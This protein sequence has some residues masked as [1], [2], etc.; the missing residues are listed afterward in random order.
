VAIPILKTK[1]YLPPE[2]A[3]AVA[4]PRLLARLDEGLR[5]GC[6]LV[7][8]SA[9]AG[10]GKTTLVSEW[11]ASHHRGG[12]R[13]E[14]GGAVVAPEGGMTLR[15]AQGRLPSLQVAW[16]SL[17]SG[18]NDPA[19]FLAYLAAALQSADVEVGHD[20]RA[21]LQSPQPPEAEAVLTALLNA[22]AEYPGPLA[23]VLDDYHEITAQEIHDA[24]LF[25]LDHLPPHVHLVL[26][27]RIDPPWPL[28]RL[29]ARQAMVELRVPDLRFTLDEA[30]TYVNDVM[31]L[32]LS[33]EQLAALDAR[34]EGWISGLQMAALALQAVALQASPSRD[35]S[36][37]RDVAAFVREF[38]GSHR[39]VLDYLVEEVLERQPAEV[40]TF[41]LRTSI[42]DRLTAPLCDALLER[43]DSQARLTAL[44]RANLFLVPLD[45]ERRWY[46]YHRLF[47]DLLRARL[48]RAEPDQGRALHLRA[49][50]WLEQND[51]PEAAIDHALAG[52]DLERAAELVE[53]HAEATLMRGEVATFWRWTDA[54]PAP[55]LRARPRLSLYSAMTL[56]WR[57]R[58][59]VAIE[60]LLQDVEA[61]EAG[62]KGAFAALRGLL[63]ALRGQ[64]APATEL[65]DRALEQL[66]PQE[67]FARTY[68][69]WVLS[70]LRVGRG[71]QDAMHP[72]PDGERA[73]GDVLALS[74]Q[75]GNVLLT[76][77]AECNR[78]EL[79]MRQG[80]L[81]RAAATY[82]R[83][84]DQITGDREESPPVAGQALIG[85]GEVARLRG[86]LGE[87]ARQFTEGIRL[88]EQWTQV[89]P[90]EGHMGLARV[91]WAQG[92][93]ARAWEALDV[94]RKLAVD[95]DLSELD[96]YSVAMVGAGFHVEQGEWEQVQRWAEMRGLYAY[97]DTPLHEAPGDSYDH[98][99]HKYELL[100][101]ARMLIAQGQAA[102]ARQALESLPALAERRGRPGLLIEVYA[103]QALAWQACG[104]R[105]RALDALERAL[106][107]GEPEGYLRPLLDEG[108]RMRSLIGDFRLR[109]SG[110]AGAAHLSAYV[111]RLLG[112]EEGEAASPPGAVPPAQPSALVEPLSERELEVLRLLNTPLSQPEI[113]ERL[114]VSINT[115]RTH[116][117]HVYEKL[118]VHAR[119]A[120]VERAE[121]LGLL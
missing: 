58:S 116:V 71:G 18:D 26:A 72:A 24:L 13:L 41:L 17:D 87:A 121:E 32:A 23:L 39:Y 37:A 20:V 55:L 49:S 16:L 97:L 78:A 107:L 19:R 84:L 110:R 89:G 21:A 108:E 102:E 111:E 83:A 30:T 34:T 80:H 3:R 103:L 109:I 7:L 63:A 57:G 4:R 99:M 53:R 44:E 106:V 10:F 113:A 96:D 115:V 5:P 2:R 101:L 11:I 36:R 51:L 79:L 1:L 47:A 82:Q 9:P 98:R 61:G 48:L 114:Y 50:L 75:A 118:G 76:F 88:L 38:D 59:T 62:L 46:R 52:H 100:V 60:S 45:G 93:R 95:Y 67:Q 90:L 81:A 66:P 120:A 54:L 104:D 74:R 56:L 85:L 6:S 27:T 25:T 31:G 40:Q 28:A 91:L 70:V 94:A 8:V 112:E 29:R 119:T 68:V 77:M 33:A 22:L 65:L 12:P 73:F 86:D 15:Q 14:P 92:E 35:E 42:L 43:T 64:A 105:E 117:K 69:T